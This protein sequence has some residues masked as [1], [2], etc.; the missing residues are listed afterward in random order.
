[1]GTP[2]G[3]KRVDWEVVFGLGKMLNN[4]KLLLV[5]KRW[6]MGQKDTQ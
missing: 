3:N 2:L 5:Q 4:T 1:M 6:N